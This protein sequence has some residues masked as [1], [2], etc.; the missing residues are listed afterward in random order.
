MR[1]RPQFEASA[2]VIVRVVVVL[3]CLVLAG[4][5]PDRTF[6]ERFSQCRDLLKERAT[7]ADPEQTRVARECFLPG[8]RTV[9]DALVAQKGDF[10]YGLKVSSLL[11]YEEVGGAPEVEGNFAYLPVKV[12]RTVHR[13]PM[14]LDTEELI[15]RFDLVELPRFL[16]PLDELGGGS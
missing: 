10:V 5:G 7:F 15:W 2:H 3:A 16:N 6:E 8:Q 13:L 14:V 9:L 12:G 1:C 11:D 4:C